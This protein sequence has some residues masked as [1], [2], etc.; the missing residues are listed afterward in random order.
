MHHTCE[1]SVEGCTFNLTHPIFE[2]H[3]KLHGLNINSSASPSV[4]RWLQIL[5]EIPVLQEMK[6]RNAIGMLFLRT[7]RKVTLDHL[8]I[9]DPCHAS[10]LG[11][12]DLLEHLNSP[13][14][15]K[16]TLSCPSTKFVPD[17]TTL[18]SLIG[19]EFYRRLHNI[20]THPMT[21]RPVLLLRSVNQRTRGRLAL[22]GQ[23][24]GNWLEYISWCMIRQGNT[25]LFQMTLCIFLSFVHLFAWNTMVIHQ[26]T[27]DE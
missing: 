2:K 17:L 10:I 4:W 3:K 20:M 13:P 24:N 25:N 9:L 21:A 8:S 7:P 19:R 12:S 6:I 11:C 16:N 1:V 26:K 15:S 5:N 18:L 27:S 22:K 14:L 23:E